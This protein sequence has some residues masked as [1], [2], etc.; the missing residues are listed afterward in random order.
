MKPLLH[1]RYLYFSDVKSWD[2]LDIFQSRSCNFSHLLLCI[3]PCPHLCSSPC[4]CFWP[5]S[6][7]LVIC[8]S[9]PLLSVRAAVVSTVSACI[10]EYRKTGK[11]GKKLDICETACR[12][13]NTRGPGRWQKHTQHSGAVYPDKWRSGWSVGRHKK[14]VRFPAWCLAAL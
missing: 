5:S 3:N 12:A 9:F 1:C 13:R 6:L 8:C 7:F 14:T 10:Y 4:F 11:G 2:S